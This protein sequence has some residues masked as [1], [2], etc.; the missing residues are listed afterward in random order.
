MK[1]GITL[2]GMQDAAEPV[3]ARHGYRDAFHKM[4][5]YVG[6]FVGIS[7]HDVGDMFGP[8]A[9]KPFVP[10]VVFNVEPV[11]EFPE[12]QIH[13]RLEDTILITANGAE[14]LTAAVPAEIDR[15]YA[16]VKQPGINSKSLVERAAR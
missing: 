1:P 15:V 8:A 5:R 10:G 4:G 3:Y 12:K 11:L 14:N 16:L 13:M 2:D 9:Q 6:H 7:V